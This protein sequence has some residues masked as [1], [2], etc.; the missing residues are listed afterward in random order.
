V[1]LLVEDV[2]EET[3]AYFVETALGEGMEMI[4]A[5]MFLFMG[6]KDLKDSTA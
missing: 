5:C 4:G 2:G 3:L 6:E 1:E